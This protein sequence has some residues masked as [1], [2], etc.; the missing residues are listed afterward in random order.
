ML[1]LFVSSRLSPR[2]LCALPECSQVTAD[3]RQRHSPLS[4][5]SVA[6]FNS[7]NGHFVDVALTEMGPSARQGRTAADHWGVHLRIF[8]ASGTPA[9]QPGLHYRV[10]P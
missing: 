6:I 1:S 7:W 9:C 8:S 4:S 3:G 5:A 2:S 10:P